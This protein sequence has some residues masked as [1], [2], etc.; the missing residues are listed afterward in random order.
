MEMKE[1]EGKKKNINFSLL[2]LKK[3]KPESGREL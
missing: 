3:S 1:I 2:Q